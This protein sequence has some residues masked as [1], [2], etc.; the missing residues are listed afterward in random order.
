MVYESLISIMETSLEPLAEMWAA[1]VKAS[2]YMDTYKKLDLE[3]LEKRGNVLFSNLLK[4][5]RTGAYNEEVESY[6]EN[7]GRSRINESFPLSEI[8]H[9]LYLE[10]KVVWSFVIW[11]EEIL[12]ELAREEMIEVMSVINNY[13]DLGSF[14]I[15]R[16]YMSE[17]VRLLEESGCFNKRQIQEILKNSSLSKERNKMPDINLYGNGLSKGILK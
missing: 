4:W 13:F 6:F 17:M 2:A 3:E 12:Y 16:G 5:L 10:K 15:I 14:Y 11:K 7:I 9:A 8:E 1:E